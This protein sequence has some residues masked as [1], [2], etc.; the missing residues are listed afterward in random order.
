MPLLAPEVGMRQILIVR[1]QSPRCLH[2][3]ELYTQLIGKEIPTCLNGSLPFTGHS[4]VLCGVL[5]EDMWSG[6]LQMVG[7]RVGSSLSS[8]TGSGSQYDLATAH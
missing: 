6:A 3:T 1:S 7:G 4:E 2:D 5:L 8:H